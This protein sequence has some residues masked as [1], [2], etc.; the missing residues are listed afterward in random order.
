MNP[1]EMSGLALLEAMRDEK[2]PAPNSQLDHA[3]HL[4]KRGR[5]KAVLFK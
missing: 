5:R 3:C 2:I 1:K 4:L